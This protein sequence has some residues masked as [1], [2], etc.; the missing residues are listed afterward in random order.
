MS[1]NA[2]FVRNQ[3][4]GVLAKGVL[5]DPVSLPRNQTIV[6]DIGL[7]S[8]FGT[9]SATVKRGVYVCKNPLFL[10][11]EF[12]VFFD[13]SWSAG[14]WGEILAS[15]N[16]SSCSEN[17]SLNCSENWFSYNLGRES[18]SESCSESSLEFRELLREWLF[19]SKSF[20]FVLRGV[21][22]LCIFEGFSG[23]S[24]LEGLETP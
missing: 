18:S 11:P 20:C 19:H 23:I 22:T 17:C 16:S 24:R 4:K 1:Q 8:A 15:T 10:V 5:Q 14:K 21:G 9:R 6:E 13:S 2:Q 3:E 7:S 12:G